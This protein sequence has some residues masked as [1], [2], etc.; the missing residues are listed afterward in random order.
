MTIHQI[1]DCPALSCRWTDKGYPFGN[2][3]P[4]T[5]K[6]TCRVRP[7]LP[8]GRD[9]EGNEGE[10]F[11]A[12]TNSYGAVSALMPDGKLLGV[13]PTNLQLLNGS[14]FYET[15][16]LEAARTLRRPPALRRMR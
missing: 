14:K 7:D 4:L 11:P 2:R 8:L 1:V 5:I 16:P 9:I 13:N 12:W 10:T 15:P 3:I 6:L